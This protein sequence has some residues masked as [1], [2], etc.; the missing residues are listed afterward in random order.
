MLDLIIF[1][2]GII[3]GSFLNVCIYRLPQNQSIVNPPSHCLN[4]NTQLK[5]LDLIPILS[6][7]LLHGKCRYCA[8]PYSP[9]YAVVEL[10]TGFL[11]LWCF[12]II[13]L[14][15]ELLKVLI[16]AAFLI[17]ITFIDYDYQ[18]IMDKIL[19]WFAGAGAVI[20]LYIGYPRI[21]D[22]LFA[23]L[24]GGA[25]LL[26][27]AVLTNGG[28]GGGD[29]K[30]VAALGFWLGVK[31]TLVMLFLTFVIGGCSG[32]LLLIFKI[33]GRK[34]YIPFGPFIASGALI[35]ILYGIKIIWW[36]LHISSG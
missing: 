17:V 32:A 7:L 4:C 16:F 20:N 6:Y 21:S 2:L 25:L 33:K 5:V 12:Q 22:M 28:M 3:I 36:Y 24:V 35:S 34:D 30:F 26:L 13:G 9:R 15:P 29:I 31:L 1:V 18:L 11:F 10:I 19:V 23:A 8:N 14:G 27:I